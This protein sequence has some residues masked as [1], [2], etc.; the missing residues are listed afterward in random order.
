V[1]VR[2]YRQLA[3]AGLARGAVRHRLDR[4]DLERVC[5][6]VYGEPGSSKRDRLSALFLRLPEGAVLGHQSAA[7]LYGFGV[8]PGDDV[9]VL[10]PA[11]V[12]RPRI[13]GVVPHEAILPV[14]DLLVMDGVPCASPARVAIDLARGHR[15]LDAIAVLD[16]A[17]TAAACT[18]DDLADEVERHAG[19]R[20]VCQAR[21][22]VPL[23]LA[24]AQCPQESHLRLV[25]VDGGLPAPEPQVWVYDGGGVARYRLDLA[26]RRKKVGIE[27]DGRSHLERGQLQRDRARMNWLDRHGW[28]MRYFTDRDL[29]RD[30]DGLVATVRYALL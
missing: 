15:R 23:A 6:G 24:G 17:L 2:T 30:A 12:P 4:G 18:S 21:Q 7:E 9:H 16:A 26:Y 1:D 27:Y 14:T 20:G 5:R 13:L 19:L 11:G 8:L 3:G 28:T 29:Y 22:L 25:M 10:V